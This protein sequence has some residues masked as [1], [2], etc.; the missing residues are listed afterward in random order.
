MIVPDKF[1]HSD[2]PATIE[3]ENE[4][5]QATP[6]VPSPTE[7]NLEVVIKAKD[8]KFYH[9]VEECFQRLGNLSKSLMLGLTN[10]IA[11]CFQA[12]INKFAQGRR[13]NYITRGKYNLKTMTATFGFQYGAG[14]SANAYQ[15]IKSKSPSPFW[16]RSFKRGLKRSGVSAKKRK[17]RKIA[18]T[19][20][21]K[22][23]KSDFLSKNLPLHTDADYGNNAADVDMDPNLLQAGIHQIVEEHRVNTPDEQWQI[24]LDTIGQFNNE[25][26][27]SRR[28]KM[29]TASIAGKILSLQDKTPNT[30]TL[31]DL[32]EP[33]NLQNNPAVQW[34]KN[35]ESKAVKLY[36]SIN[37]LTVEPAGLFVSLEFPMIGASPDG[38]VGLDG[39]IEVKCPFKERFG[40]PADTVLRKQ[41]ALRLSK[42]NGEN[43]LPTFEMAKNSHYYAQIVTQLHVANR[44]WCDFVVW[45]QGPEA[46]GGSSS[47][48][49]KFE[50]PEGFIHVTRIQ[51]NENTLE[52]WNTIR[53]KM[54]KFFERIWTRIGRPSP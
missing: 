23:T 18:W 43:G 37:N 47:T 7:H 48:A 33:P 28:K 34:G 53:N 54:E 29:L 36:E 16:L 19:K 40:L 10:N 27:I 52:K 21:S 46:A 49:M 14:W 22:L 41:Y 15:K 5:P 38:L 39:M 31:D 26:Y 3:D 35:M 4:A 20:A 50:K 25:D 6:V 11:E 17:P 12:Q 51:K 30:S 42:K 44:S 8:A 13:I 9:V 1:K 45:T 32:I 2:Q 24:H